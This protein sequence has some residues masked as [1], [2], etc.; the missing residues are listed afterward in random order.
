ML[1][2][3]PY[4]YACLDKVI[5]D[6]EQN[7]VI[8]MSKEIWSN[9][10]TS[11]SNLIVLKISLWYV[12]GLGASISVCKNILYISK[13]FNT[14]KFILLAFYICIYLYEIELQIF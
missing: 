12:L 10:K 6:K 7:I 13:S 5:L 1:L 4:F 3:F 9:F 11:Y 8:Y 14:W 2:H